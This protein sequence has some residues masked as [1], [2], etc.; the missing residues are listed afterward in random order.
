MKYKDTNLNIGFLYKMHVGIDFC[1]QSFVRLVKWQIQ[2]TKFKFDFLYDEHFH[3]DGPLVS[4]QK[5]KICF[6][7]GN[8]FNT[9]C[10]H[11][12]LEY[13]VSQKM[14]NK[15]CL[16]QWQKGCRPERM[17]ILKEFLDSSTIHG[18]SHISNPKVR[19]NVW[20]CFTFSLD[21]RPVLWPRSLGW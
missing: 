20:G 11:Y 19:A 7:S 5:L 18:L 14:H 6:L 2:D 16:I 3:I 12:N 13:L 1:C 4:Q 21:L 17:E 9:Q 10:S 15:K 8:Y